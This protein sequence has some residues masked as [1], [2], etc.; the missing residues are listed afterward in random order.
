M[1]SIGAVIRDQNGT[2]VAGLA[3]NNGEASNVIAELWA[4][5]AGPIL[6]KSHNI[7]E[8]HVETDSKTVYF[9]FCTVRRMKTVHHH[10]LRSIQTLLDYFN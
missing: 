1:A 3:A 4:I 7:T 8:I 2:F 10:L 5:R 6:A 9:F